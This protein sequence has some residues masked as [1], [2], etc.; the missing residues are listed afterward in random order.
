[1][2]AWTPRQRRSKKT[3]TGDAPTRTAL[4]TVMLLTLVGAAHAQSCGELRFERNK[5]FKR[6]GYCF[7]TSDMIR[8]FGNA[9]CMYDNEAE[10]PLSDEGRQEVAEIVRMER[11]ARCR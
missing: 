9:G 8:A 6:A 1:M 3:T 5:V 10:V 7:H 2:V 4:A 11:E